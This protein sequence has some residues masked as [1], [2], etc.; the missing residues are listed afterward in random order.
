[1]NPDQGM[2]N[3][4]PLLQKFVFNEILFFVGLDVLFDGLETSFA[5]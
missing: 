5:V 1:V 3:P 2:P 4:F